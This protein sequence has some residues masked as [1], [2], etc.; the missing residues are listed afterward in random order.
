MYID[1]LA[2]FRIANHLMVYHLAIARI[3][4]HA[5]SIGGNIGRSPANI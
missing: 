5:A 4:E 1:G 2:D 3:L